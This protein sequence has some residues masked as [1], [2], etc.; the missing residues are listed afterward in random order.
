MMKP[1]NKWEFDV[2]GG[3]D[4]NTA[5]DSYMPYALGELMYKPNRFQV[6]IQGGVVKNGNVE[7]VV[8]VKAKIKIF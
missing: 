1:P 3:I 4:Y 5:K 6:G 7:P 2:V 8:G